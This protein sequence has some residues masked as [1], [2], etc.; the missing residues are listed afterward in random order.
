MLVTG[1]E[2]AYGGGRLSGKRE[3][4]GKEIGKREKKGKEMGFF[5]KFVYY[6]TTRPAMLKNWLLTSLIVLAV[7]VTLAAT[8]TIALLMIAGGADELPVPYHR[9][10]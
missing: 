1:H 9:T 7:M 5:S 2:R 6:L 4:K 8:L 3:K 10:N